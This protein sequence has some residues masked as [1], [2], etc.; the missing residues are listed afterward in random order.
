[1]L[2]NLSRFTLNRESTFPQLQWLVWSVGRMRNAE[3]KFC[4]SPV[5]V[6]SETL[7]IQN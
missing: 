1:M 2:W 5:N 6:A 3:Y 7:A 4:K